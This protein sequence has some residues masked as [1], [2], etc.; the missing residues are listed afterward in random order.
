MSVLTARLDSF[1]CQLFHGLTFNPCFSVSQQI[2]VCLK[3]CMCLTVKKKVAVVHNFKHNCLEK[4]DSFI[5]SDLIAIPV[6][7]FTC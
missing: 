6:M 5:F 4:S 7:G 3:L 1:V 2:C